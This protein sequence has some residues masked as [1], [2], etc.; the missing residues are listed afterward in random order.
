MN[1]LAK[2]A[3]F[4][5]VLAVVLLGGLILIAYRYATDAPEWV[6]F[7]SNSA[8][9]KSGALSSFTVV[10]SDGVL[11][12]DTAQGASYCTDAA[13]RSSVLHLLGDGSNTPSDVTGFHGDALTGFDYINGVY[14]T[15]EEQGKMTVTV[16]SMVQAAAFDAMQGKKGTV[17][18]YNYQTGEI[19]CMLSMPTYDIEN[20]PESIYETDENGNRVEKDEYEGLYYNRFIRSLYIPGSTFKLV[21]AAAAIEHIADIDERT[22]ECHGSID[23]GGRAVWCHNENGHGSLTFEQALAKSCNVVFAQIA[24]ELGEKILTD[25]T[26]R[27]HIT[28]TLSFDGLTTVKGG[29]HLSQA[30]RHAVAWAGIGQSYNQINPCQFMTFVGAIANGGKSAVPY[31]VENVMYGEDTEYCAE[32]KTET[33]LSKQ[34][35]AR[36]AQMMRYAVETNYSWK[37]NFAGIECGGKSGTAER[38]DGTKDALFAGFSSDPDYPLAYIVVVENGTSGSDDCLPIV[39]QVLNACVAAIDAR[40]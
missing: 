20:P 31:V 17:G 30:D 18:V 3:Y 10:S 29:I 1:K 25:Y 15:G 23:I 8:I 33:Y 39:Q 34:T 37:C 24:D 6:A 35:S 4:T 22:F 32:T 21:T 38:G 5:L 28:D 27:V 9:Q 26:N 40:S 19:L 12:L 14:S 36:L 7:R 16:N 2:R 13:V 11:L